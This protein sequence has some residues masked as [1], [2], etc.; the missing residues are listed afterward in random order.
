MPS[1]HPACAVVARLADYFTELHDGGH[2]SQITSYWLE[3]YKQL[4]E[5]RQQNEL[6]AER[7]RDTV[8]SIPQT[9]RGGKVPRRVLGNKFVFT[10]GI[11]G[12][13]REHKLYPRVRKLRGEVGLKASAL[14]TAA[15]LVHGNRLGERRAT[16]KLKA[17]KRLGVPIIS[18]EE[19][20]ELLGKP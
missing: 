11:A 6:A 9:P 17:A 13:P 7:S 12:W 19:F 10:G 8:R 18:E 5:E 2:S 1:Q 20:L 16:V 4:W 14:P 3:R 15:C